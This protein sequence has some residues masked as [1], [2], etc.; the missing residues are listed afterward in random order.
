MLSPELVSRWSEPQ[1]PAPPVGGRTSKPKRAAAG[2]LAFG[3]EVKTDRGEYWR[4]D[5]PVFELW[6]E[7]QRWLTALQKSQPQTPEPHA[8]IT[9]LRAALPDKV[10]LVNLEQ[11]AERIFLAGVVHT[12][13]ELPVVTQLL[14][15]GDNEE[16]AIL[17]ALDGLF[18]GK[19]ALITFNGKTCDWP[20]VLERRAHHDLGPAPWS[21][22]LTHCDLLHHARRRWK[23]RLPNCK[24]QTLEQLICGRHRGDAGARDAAQAYHDYLATSD[25]AH[26]AGVLHHNALDLVTLWQLALWL[27]YA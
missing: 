3:L 18:A 23:S 1:R 14:A 4:N 2:E 16:A 11:C 13:Q 5:V 12:H 6:P 26:L 8:E 22:A 19:D 20:A 15:R 9:A 21:T 24:L 27:A 7:Q 17:S 10:I 25:S